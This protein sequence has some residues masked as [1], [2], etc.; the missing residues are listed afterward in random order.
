[1]ESPTVIILMRVLFPV[2]AMTFVGALHCSIKS[3]SLTLGL[4]IKQKN[5]N[6]CK[7]VCG[8]SDFTYCST[9]FTIYTIAVFVPP[10]THHFG[11]DRGDMI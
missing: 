6:K 10:C 5:V 8:E 11:M 2:K 1:M 7:C 9:D 3:C 4:N